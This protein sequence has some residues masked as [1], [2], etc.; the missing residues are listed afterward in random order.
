[1]TANLDDTI[2]HKDDLYIVVTEG[3][4]Q[5]ITLTARGIGTTIW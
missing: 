1:M 4:T 5:Q 3:D 2:N